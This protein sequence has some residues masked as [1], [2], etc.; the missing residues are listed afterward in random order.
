MFDS[1][2]SDVMQ[3]ILPTRERKTEKQK[4]PHRA[5]SLA[6]DARMV[7]R[8]GGWKGYASEARPA[9]TTM[10]RGLQRVEATREGW[11]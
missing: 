3:R 6:Q 10:L 1:D 4:N 8:L 5:G 7:A 9:P 2:E 11:V